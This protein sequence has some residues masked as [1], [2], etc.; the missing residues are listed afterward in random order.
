MQLATDKRWRHTGG[1]AAMNG[2]GQIENIAAA[3]ES[4]MEAGIRV[5]EVLPQR[6]QA[7]RAGDNGRRHELG[8]HHQ[9]G[10]HGAEHEPGQ[11]LGTL[12]Q[13]G[14]V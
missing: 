5:F 11:A 9:R 13:R 10:N 1:K 14:E 6:W 7:I 4:C 12:F 3:H 8:Q 2:V